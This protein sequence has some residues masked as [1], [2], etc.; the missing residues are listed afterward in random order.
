MNGYLAMN[1]AGKKSAGPTRNAAAQISAGACMPCGTRSLCRNP[2]NVARAM[3]RAWSRGSTAPGR[4]MGDDVNDLSGDGVDVRREHQR[5]ERVLERSGV[6]LLA[7]PHGR[8]VRGDPPLAQDQDLGADTLHHLELVRAV[9]DDPAA[10]GQ[11]LDQAT[12]HQRR[13]DVQAGAR[14]IEHH[15]G[16]VVQKRRR[17]Q[18]LLPH[19]FRIGAHCGVAIR[20][21]SEDAEK[22][23][24][25]S[26][27]LRPTQ[28][29]QSRAEGQVLGAA[30]PGIELRFLGNVA[31]SLLVAE[32]VGANV[33]AV[34]RDRAAGRLE[35]AGEHSHGRRLARSIGAEQPEDRAGLDPEVHIPDAGDGRVVLRQAPGFEHDDSRHRNGG[36]VPGVVLPR[37]LYQDIRFGLRTAL[38]NKGVTALAVVCLAIGVGLNTMM[39][40]VTDGVLLDPLPYKDSDRLVELTLTNHER[41]IRRSN[42]SWLDAREWR[43]RNRSLS[44][45]APLQ[46]RNFTVSDGGDADRYSGAAVS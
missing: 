15:D 16:R 26:L 40:S 2:S 9:D 32:E 8:R 45:I 7:Q 13:A 6:D 22:R 27:R 14:L 43:E 18:N 21:Q 46:Y 28:A 1:C 35:Q 38:K 29:A 24:D 36:D 10:G 37:M 12:H 41:G 19:A 31:E 42:L 39:F 33:G 5:A 34:Q 20:L 17:Q 30:H 23:V 44:S 3:V 11:P 4:S 25:P